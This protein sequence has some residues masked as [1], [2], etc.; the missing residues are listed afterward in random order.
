MQTAVVGESVRAGRNYSPAAVVLS[1]LIC[2]R[3]Y[4]YVFAAFGLSINPNYT[5]PD[6]L[7][8]PVMIT[9]DGSG[10]SASDMLV[11]AWTRWDGE[12][13]LAIAT[14]GYRPVI[15]EHTNIAFFPLYPLLMAGL[16][17]LFG[18][19]VFANAVAGIVIS[20]VAL[21]GALV[22]LFKIVERDFSRT[23]AWR[24][25]AVL[26]LFPTSFFF[27]AVYTESLALLLSV[28]TFWFM[29]REQ[30]WLAG[31]C[32]ALLAATRLPGVLIAPLLAV[33]YLHSVGWN[34][35]R[36]RFEIL[37]AVLPLLGLGA[38]MAYQWT[39]FGS[40]MAFLES[41]R[42]WNQQLSA[43]WMTIIRS[44]DWAMYQPES[45]PYFTVYLAT[46]LLFTV[47]GVLAFRRLPLAYGLTFW[48]LT[49]PAF[50]TDKLLSFPRYMLLGFPAFILLAQ[51]LQSR[52]SMLLYGL[53]TGGLGIIAVVL[54]VNYA[55]VA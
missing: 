1:L 20:H 36:V 34:V 6:D 49:L 17:S 33:V 43:P 32:G 50:L 19:G 54:F 5:R 55:W 2:W 40:P 14:Q 38:F 41:Q 7:I 48:A 23:L 26:L 3:L 37:A 51:L 10:V 47:L 31:A 16:G 21:F 42:V 22:V 28:S 44:I 53:I 13:Y 4:L 8:A 52:R 11:R 18:G 12:H 29:R 39:V 27:G 30:W 45:W 25:I 15:D 24:T 46:W 9:E 35:R